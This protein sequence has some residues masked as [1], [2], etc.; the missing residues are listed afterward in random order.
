MVSDYSWITANNS[1][2]DTEKPDVAPM[3]TSFS[4]FNVLQG[5]RILPSVIV[6]E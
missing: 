3:G 6:A 2:V 4:H 5:L 1:Q